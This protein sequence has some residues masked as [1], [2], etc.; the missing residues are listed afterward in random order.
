MDRMPHTQVWLQCL[1]GMYDAQQAWAL[2]SRAEFLY[3]D[4]SRQHASEARWPNRT[5]L[6]VRILPGLAIYNS[7]LEVNDDPEKVLA[8]MEPL[9]KSA[10]F[11][12]RMQ[13]IRLL[14]NLPDPFP[15]VRPVL[16]M[17]TRDDYLPGSQEVVEDTPDCYAVTVYRCFI[18]DVLT[19]HHAAELTAL[20]CKTDDWLAEALPKI[21]W[22]R[23]QTLGRGGDCCDFRWCRQTAD[24][25]IH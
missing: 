13:G 8:E 1:T 24:D 6:K 14:N 15:L 11:T 23:T 19:R 5:A 25:K 21:S 18:L 9:F 7:L 12:Q 20:Y 22:Q 2:I 4:Y 3:L 16:K 10:F 17:M